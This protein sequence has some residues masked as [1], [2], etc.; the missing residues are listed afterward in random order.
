MN[1]S[2]RWR[3]RGRGSF[4]ELKSIFAQPEVMLGGRVPW[5]ALLD[6]LVTKTK[7]KGTIDHALPGLKRLRI[8]SLQVFTRVNCP[9]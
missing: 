6:E 8:W 1:K 9:T 5:E 3:E 4:R 2:S 7:L